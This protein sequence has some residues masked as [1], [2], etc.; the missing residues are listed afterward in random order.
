MYE[1]IFAFHFLDFFLFLHYY[2][3]FLSRGNQ[4]NDFLTTRQNNKSKMPSSV[5][6]NTNEGFTLERSTLFTPVTKYLVEVP[7]SQLLCNRLKSVHYLHWNIL[8]PRRQWTRIKPT[9]SLPGEPNVNKIAFSAGV[10]SRCSWLNSN[11]VI[12][13]RISGESPYTHLQ[14]QMGRLFLVRWRIRHFG[15]IATKGNTLKPNLNIL[16]QIRKEK[17]RTWIDNYDNI[18]GVSKT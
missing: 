12:G 11:H 2:N 8:T 15:K 6:R 3:F 13:L 16:F 5:Y 7:V 14:N 9:I 4:L 18:L 17:D 1:T 10:F